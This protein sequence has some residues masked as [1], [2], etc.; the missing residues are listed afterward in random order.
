[1]SRP[2]MMFWKECSRHFAALALLSVTVSAGAAPEVNT[3]LPDQLI[4]QGDF[5]PARN[6]LSLPQ[7]P[8]D[9]LSQV[10][11]FLQASAR[12]ANPDF[13]GEANALL[14]RLSQHA[15]TAPVQLRR[16]VIQQRLHQF[17]TSSKTLASV[18]S[19]N[20][21][22]AQAL[23]TAFVVDLTRGEASLAEA[24]CRRYRAVKSDLSGETCDALLRAWHGDIAGAAQHLS[25]AIGSSTT[26][27][28][29]NET[30][31]ALSMLAELQDVQFPEESLRLWAL[32]HALDPSDLY[33]RQRY[34][35]A[36][37][38]RGD[39]Q[40]V[41]SMTAGWEEVESLALSRILALRETDKKAALALQRALTQRFDQ[42]RARPD[43]LHAHEY[44]RFLLDVEARP[45]EAFSW[46]LKNWQVQKQLPDFQLLVRAARESG[47]ESDLPA[48]VPWHGRG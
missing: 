15:V 37:L 8:A 12:T 19:K 23:L 6:E 20:P 41:L 24:R 36:L 5:I 13:L 31:W 39:Y 28:A 48:V 11:E 46:A 29:D 34:V 22:H 3:P 18:L 43:F 2:L 47:Q 33:A 10:D 42:A 1:M 27:G 7:A 21:D 17:D 26:R 4:W 14:D 45:G 35:D 25:Q 40:R 30:I 38:A 16:A 32:T 9:M 44:A